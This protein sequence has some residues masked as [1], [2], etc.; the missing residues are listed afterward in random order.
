MLSRVRSVPYKDTLSP[1]APYLGDSVLSDLK[2]I[3]L[4]FQPTKIFVSHPA[5]TN[6]DHRALYLFLKITLW[7]LQEV[8]KPPKVYPFIIHVVGWPKPRGYFP[9]KILD[10]PADLAN[11]EIAWSSLTL[12]E[13]EIGKKYLAVKQY[14]SQNKYAPKYLPT[15]A[16]CN[17]IFGDYPEVP[18]IR[19]MV[20]EVA[21]Q[22]VGTGDENLPAKKAGNTNRISSLAYAWQ[23]NNFLIKLTL[24]HTIDQTMGVSI[25]LLGYRPDMPFG[26]MPKLNLLVGIDGFH[27]KDR[28]KNVHSKD[29]QFT[30][31]DKELVFVI[32]LYLLGSPD[33]ILSSA[34]TLLY[35]LTL[36][37][38]A[39]RTLLLK[40]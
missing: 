32:P 14:A 4:D 5:D 2:Q 1:N 22:Y 9:E 16:R 20:S 23:G 17:E 12:D 40:Q 31:K 7:D 3:I 37:E 35:D 15:F 24:K 33:R 19:Q 29:I 26:E 38:T 25:F 28:R 27:V 34:K 30:A 13:L 10:V 11:S 39:W 36:D 18:L 6:R 21:W 8:I